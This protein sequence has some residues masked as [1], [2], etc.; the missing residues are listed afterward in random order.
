MQ[1]IGWFKIVMA[2]PCVN[3]QCVGFAEHS[4][5]NYELDTICYAC[6]RNADDLVAL[7]FRQAG[8]LG[9]WKH[10]HPAFVSN[11][12]NQILL[13]V[14]YH[15]WGQDLPTLGRPE[16]SLARLVLADQVANFADESVTGVAR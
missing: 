13:I 6:A 10:E 8:Q 15:S 3:G 16:H 11:G 2:F 9:D 1:Q 4:E 5:C 12:N 7:A 14:V